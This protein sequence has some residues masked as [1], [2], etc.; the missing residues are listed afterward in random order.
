MF[1]VFLFGGFAAP[2]FTDR[3]ATPAGAAFVGGLL[4]ILGFAAAIVCGTAAV[5]RRRAGPAVSAS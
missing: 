5:R 4:Q 3:L 1:A 2:D